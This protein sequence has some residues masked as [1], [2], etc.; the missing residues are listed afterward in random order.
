MDGHLQCGGRNVR[1]RYFIA[2]VTGKTGALAKGYNPNPVGLRRVGGWTDQHFNSKA[3]CVIMAD[4]IALRA[5]L[6]Y[7]TDTVTIPGF[8]GIQV[9]DQVRIFEQVTAEGYLHYVKGISSDLDLETGKWTYSLD[10]QW[11]GENPTRKWIFKPE[12]LQEETKK[13]LKYLRIVDPVP[14]TG[15]G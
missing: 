11:L 3:D 4:L 6:T 2:D 9:D 7:R 13:Y 15:G 14:G 1:E 10:T 12:N 5:L 8:P